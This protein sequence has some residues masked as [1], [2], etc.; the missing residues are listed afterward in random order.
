MSCM[1]VRSVLFHQRATLAASG[2]PSMQSLPR[3]AWNQRCTR[4]SLSRLK[5]LK[6]WK[7]Q[8]HK[9]GSFSWPSRLHPLTNTEA[10]I[11][12]IQIESDACWFL[13]LTCKN[14]SRP[15]SPD[16]SNKKHFRWLC[17]PL[18]ASTA[19]AV[20]FR[21]IQDWDKLATE[22]ASYNI[23]RVIPLI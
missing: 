6:A 13:P 22:V 23:F 7:K 14:C 17:S 5:G 4:D 3:K 8:V 11:Q 12:R 9:R 19:T 18:I 20:A 10:V 1:S 21:A 2:H 15:Q 16:G